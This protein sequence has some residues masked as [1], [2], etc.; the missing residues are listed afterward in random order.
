MLGAVWPER[1]S[2]LRVAGSIPAGR[3]L[4]DVLLLDGTNIN[5]SLVK[6]GWCWWYRKYAPIDT[7]LEGLEKNAREAKFKDELVQKKI[8]PQATY[9]KIKDQ[10]VARQK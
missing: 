2:K 4:A 10:I 6:A 9:D 1:T 7:V 8:M 3:T 5:H